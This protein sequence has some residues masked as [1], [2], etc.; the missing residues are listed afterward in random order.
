M[1]RIRSPRFA[2]TVR[3]NLPL[4]VRIVVASALLAMLVAAAFAVLVIALSNLRT[5]TSE[6]NRSKD[7]TSAT[8]LLE[9]NVVAAEASLRGFVNTG[10]P[11]FLKAWRDAP[12]TLSTSAAAVERR[13]VYDVGQARRAHR[14]TTMVDEYVSDYAVP[15]VRI[16]GGSPSVARS[17]LARRDRKSTRLNSSHIQ[18]YRMPSSA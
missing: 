7:M 10:D 16:A 9:Q 3:R 4:V 8:L 11:R 2:R 5:T 14:L 12:A 15:L 1:D 6:A 13:A 17:S 18:K